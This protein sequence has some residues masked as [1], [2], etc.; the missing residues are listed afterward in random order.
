M[1]DPSVR[2]VIQLKSRFDGGT[3]SFLRVV[4]EVFPDLFHAVDAEVG[5]TTFEFVTE[6]RIGGWKKLEAWLRSLQNLPVE[7]A[8]DLL[9]EADIGFNGSNASFWGKGPVTTNA[10]FDRLCQHLVG[11]TAKTPTG[12]LRVHRFLGAFRFIGSVSM[13]LMLEEVHHQ[14]LSLAVAHEKVASHVDALVGC[15][16]ERSSANGSTITSQELLA[17]AGLEHCT[18]L[19]HP[20][21]IKT[22]SR[23]K[24]QEVLDASGY[25]P[26][27]DVRGV[28]NADPPPHDAAA[29]QPAAD[30]WI[31][32]LTG[33]SGYGK[34]WALA[35]AADAAD[36]VFTAY[37][38]ATAG[39]VDALAAEFVWCVILGRD[40]AIPLERI[41]AR[42]REFSIGVSTGKPWL[43]LCVHQVPE[44]AALHALLQRPFQAWGVRLLV[45]V[46][47]PVD[48][49]TLRAP[50]AAAVVEVPRFS[51]AQLRLYLERR[52]GASRWSKLPEGVLDFLRVPQNARL[53]ADI[54]RGLPEDAPAWLPDNEFVLLD[55]SWQRLGGMLGLDLQTLAATA[56]V[57]DEP[58]RLMPTWTANQVRKSGFSDPALTQAEAEGW[59]R[60][61]RASNGAARFEFSHERM[62]AHALARDLADAEGDENAWTRVKDHLRSNTLS[63][64]P[65]DWCWMRLE[66]DPDEAAADRVISV[67]DEALP[68]VEVRK[69]YRDGLG[70]LGPRSLLVYR[71]RIEA[72][73]CAGET[74]GFFDAV[75]GLCLAAREMDADAVRDT[76][77]W[78]LRNQDLR[79]CSVGMRLLAAH[80]DPVL[81]P[82]AWASHERQL[83]EFLSLD[84]P[85]LQESAGHHQRRDKSREALGA[86]VP[87]NETWLLQTCRDAGTAALDLTLREDLLLLL[88]EATRGGSAWSA[89]KAEVLRWPEEALRPALA[90]ACGDA[91][92]RDEIGRI[93]SWI[94]EAL[95]DRR[96]GENGALPSLL[97]SLSK[98]DPARAAG[99]LQRLLRWE[100]SGIV[101]RVLRR[102]TAVD[103]L[104]AREAVK[105]LLDSDPL[106]LSLLRRM[107]LSPSML[108]PAG[109][110][111]LVGI[112]ERELAR[113]DGQGPREAELE[114]AVSLLLRVA[115]PACLAVLEEHTSGGFATRIGDWLREHMSPRPGA[116]RGLE[117]LARSDGLL[118]LA[119][120]DPALVPGVLSS[121]L[122][123]C[124]SDPSQLESIEKLIAWL[125]SEV[126]LDA[127]AGALRAVSV[128]EWSS[129]G[130]LLA[131]EAAELLVARGAVEDAVELL[132]DADAPIPDTLGTLLPPA[133]EVSRSCR[134]RLLGALSSDRPGRAASALILLGLLG[135]EEVVE[136]SIV[137]LR[138]AAT[139]SGETEDALKEGERRGR[140]SLAALELAGPRA[141]EAK[142]AIAALLSLPAHQLR[143]G[144]T[145]VRIDAAFAETALGGRLNDLGEPKLLAWLAA[146]A[147]DPSL[148]ERAKSR[149]AGLLEARLKLTGIEAARAPA[150]PVLHPLDDA[151][152]GAVMSRL[153]TDARDLV[154]AAAAGSDVFGG[155]GLRREAIRT[156]TTADPG[157]G[158]AAALAALA[159]DEIQRREPFAVLASSAD[160][161]RVAGAFLGMSE[162][163]P[164][165]LLAAMAGVLTA[166]DL[167]RLLEALRSDDPEMQTRACALMPDAACNHAMA[168]DELRALRLSGTPQVDRAATA[169]LRRLEG[170]AAAEALVSKLEGCGNPLERS[171]LI[172][173]AE[174][175]GDPGVKGGPL[176][177]WLQRALAATEAA[178]LWNSRLWSHA[179]SSREKAAR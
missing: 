139:E 54:V 89:V 174:R 86:C 106:P 87:L 105:A 138:Q 128:G 67:L 72:E 3:W 1:R 149:I 150:G 97:V 69:L 73:A 141:A 171:I 62:F 112:V 125:P 58:R 135:L 110:G 99:D 152:L 59:L 94:D 96:P 145:L 18:S 140:I 93:A 160:P 24:L 76:T 6:G 163:L 38:S 109:V 7:N 75:N 15:V 25:R 95:A 46:A 114:P 166:N 120:L 158:F 33:P 157:N 48:A 13:D 22:R 121:W 41:G 12:R 2:R 79:L 167:P 29:A 108:S 16:L 129:A 84:A 107:D 5:S 77:R 36:T 179:R 100:M 42:L 28:V 60:R 10:V 136:P 101:G 17:S 130:P 80:P 170:V 151:V 154:Q 172:Q 37:I 169:T 34:T 78:F 118:L 43:T 82:E 133:T 156:F 132:L 66:A 30:P 19:M 127:L 111:S 124:K 104:A 45:E 35:A 31:Q 74:F 119:R 165:P 176:P 92:D 39:Q 143:A 123:A 85:T 63:R 168:L 173:Q 178:P 113:G 49:G 50:A 44:P 57:L 14:V 23:N 51:L 70:Q 55:R 126:L 175:I 90:E 4:K 159:D 162:E 116:G 98:L 65:L 26:T 20:E 47:G 131:M 21:L 52:G 102:L 88:H 137:M 32:L 103:L 155:S 91:R 40:M 134:G 61:S 8:T 117:R 68:R 147:S 56:P 27:D 11:E 71:R 53:Y 122:A 81:L 64:V 9:P 153:G 161:V 177:S 142:E 148:R 146:E 144:C 164:I 115:E 83:N